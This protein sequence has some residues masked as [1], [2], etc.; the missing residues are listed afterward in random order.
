MVVATALAERLAE[1]LLVLLA[2]ASVVVLA[3]FGPVVVEVAV[4]VLVRAAVVEA[5]PVTVAARSTLVT[6]AVVLV[7][8][9]DVTD[10][11]A[12]EVVAAANV[13]LLIVIAC[14]VEAVAVLVACAAERS[15]VDRVTANV[16]LDA[17]VVV[18]PA[19]TL[20]VAVS[21]VDTD[22]KVEA[23]EERQVLFFLC[24]T[25]GKS[26]PAV[27]VVSAALVVALSVVARDP[28]GSKAS[29]SKGR[30]YQSRKSRKIQSGDLRTLR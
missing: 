15:A 5:K 25:S 1:T 14:V 16:V 22:R 8:T 12:R 4:T 23:S 11:D 30:L 19:D 2:I 7:D 24:V 20:V 10:A 9:V 6:C 18:S 21:R 26:A 29:M 13:A 27:V 28:G 17:T 3:A